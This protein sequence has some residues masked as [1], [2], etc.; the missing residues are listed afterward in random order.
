MSKYHCPEC[1]GSC[2]FECCECGS[3]ATCEACTGTGLDNATMDVVAFL[4]AVTAHEGARWS[5]RENGV[6]IGRVGAKEFSTASIDN[7]EWK[8]LYADFER[9][10]Q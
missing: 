5:I 4:A 2:E 1:S 6:T 9:K 10:P 3:T 7:P 8:I